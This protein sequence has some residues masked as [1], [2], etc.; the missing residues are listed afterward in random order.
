MNLFE[1]FKDVE[2]YFAFFFFFDMLVSYALQNQNE[3]KLASFAICVLK[4]DYCL[5]WK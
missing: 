5:M 2:E 3:L 1:S 4:N